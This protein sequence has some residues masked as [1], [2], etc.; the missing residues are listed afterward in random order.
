MKEDLII[1]QSPTKANNAMDTED[2]LK[3]FHLKVD[4]TGQKPALNLKSMSLK[5]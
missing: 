2:M 5:D 3:I 1:N 4:N